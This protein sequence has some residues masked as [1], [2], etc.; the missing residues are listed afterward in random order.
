MN[1]YETFLSLND[2]SVVLEVSAG[3][4][5]TDAIV[6][7]DMAA[8]R[9]G[10]TLADFAKRYTFTN[11]EVLG[12]GYY[13]YFFEPVAGESRMGVVTS[14]SDDTLVFTAGDFI[15]F[16][17]TLYGANDPLNDSGAILRFSITQA[18]DYTLVT[19]AP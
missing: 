8:F 15:T 12:T 6:I 5:I 3:N 2:V 16:T 9:A 17:A 14:Y 10:V 13:A 18:S 4:A 11:V 19:P 1:I 7:S